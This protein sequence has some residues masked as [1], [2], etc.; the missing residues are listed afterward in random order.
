MEE[1]RNMNKDMVGKLFRNRL[2]GRPSD[3]SVL[4]KRFF[5]FV[6]FVYIQP[7]IVG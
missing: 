1:T 7:K 5:S 2:L 4:K 3:S 6:I